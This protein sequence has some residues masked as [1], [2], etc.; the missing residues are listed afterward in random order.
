[1]PLPL[2][3]VKTTAV[4]ALHPLRS[5]ILGLAMLCLLVQPMLNA[6]HEL[7]DIEH[8]L[9][10]QSADE[11]STA[12]DGKGVAGGLDGVLHG[13]EGCLHSTAMTASSYCWPARI[14]R[15]APPVSE[16]AAIATSPLSRFLRPPI[17]A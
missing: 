5:L 8:A 1:M 4:I 9:A 15:S 3:S 6:A 16:L 12:A 7:H 10:G 13:F 14:L 2:N 11:A 17:T